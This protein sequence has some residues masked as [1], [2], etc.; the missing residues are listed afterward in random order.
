M[1]GG[2][3]A[4]CWVKLRGG[5]RM[6]NR[7]YWVLLGYKGRGPETLLVVPRIMVKPFR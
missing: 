3:L 5:S 7:E 6:G 2:N 4:V 1:D